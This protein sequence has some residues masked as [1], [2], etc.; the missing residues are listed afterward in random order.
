MALLEHLRETFY[1]QPSDGKDGFSDNDNK[2]IKDLLRRVVD[3]EKGFK[4]FSANINIEA[5]LRELEKL[6]IAV[7]SKASAVEFVNLKGSHGNPI[8]NLY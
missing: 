4:N 5:I 2:L 1:N 8:L 7:N 3:L 6:N